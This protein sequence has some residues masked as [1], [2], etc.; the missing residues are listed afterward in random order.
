[1]DTKEI[2]HR[3]ELE[4]ENVKEELEQLKR[5]LLNASEDKDSSILFQLYNISNKGKW[6][7]DLLHIY[8]V[9]F[10]KAELL[11]QLEEEG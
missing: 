2:K 8:R 9:Q 6:A 7:R 4:I 10:A 5:S 3:I 11:T 1:M